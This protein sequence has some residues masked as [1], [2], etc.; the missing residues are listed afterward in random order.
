MGTEYEQPR[1]LLVSV[2]YALKAAEAETL[3]GRSADEF[4]L[5]KDLET[6]V[7]RQLE[8]Q[9][10]TTTIR[11][12]D[13]AA[14]EIDAPGVRST[15]S[16]TN[17]SEVVFIDQLGTGH[18]LRGRSTTGVAITGVSTALTG[19]APGVSGVSKADIGKGILGRV[20]HP[21]GLTMGIRGETLSTA[22]RGI[23]GIASAGSGPTIG[24]QAVTFSPEGVGIELVTKTVGGQLFRGLSGQ[25]AVEVFSI[26]GTGDVTAASFTGDGSGLTGVTGASPAAASAPAPAPV[27][28][29]ASTSRCPSDHNS[30]TPA[31]PKLRLKAGR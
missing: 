18:A 4:V 30:A 26:S 1:I 13:A 31:S 16:D 12:G 6:Q 7:Q 11:V 25:P 29:Q 2:P 21:T 28:S 20:T 10:A 19:P 5:N 27:A 15:F 3:G 22:G 23:V 14:K 24:I 8:E 9:A 17:T